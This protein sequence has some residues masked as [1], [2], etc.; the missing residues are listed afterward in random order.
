MSFPSSLSQYNKLRRDNPQFS[1]PGTQT[2]VSPKHVAAVN[3]VGTFDVCCCV[4]TDKEDCEIWC[5]GC[6]V[7][8]CLFGSVVKMKESEFMKKEGVCDGSGCP[9]C[10]MFVL[11]LLGSAG[12]IGPCITG[13]VAMNCMDIYANENCFTRFFSMVLCFPC[14]T[15]ADFKSAQ[16]QVEMN[17]ADRVDVSRDERHIK[18]F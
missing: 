12:M 16:K 5:A 9:C 7:P 6:V 18:P 11:N 14:Q 13:C 2:F 15:C 17:T 1:A 8:Y 10:G 3:I 4:A